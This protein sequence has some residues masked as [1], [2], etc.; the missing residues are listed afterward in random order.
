MRVQSKSVF[1][2]FCSILAVALAQSL[3][4]H[5]T[6]ILLPSSS[7]WN[8]DIAYVFLQQPSRGDF[9]LASINISSTLS[10][11]NLSLETLSTTLPFSTTG[12]D[13]FIPS[14]ST[15]GE[16]LVYAGTC[17]TSDGASLWTFTPTNTSSV[18]NGTWIKET[19]TAGN[20]SS[21]DLLGADFLSRGFSFS[22]LV[23]ANASQ[24][25]TYIFGGMCPKSGAT[26]STW[27]SDASYSNRMLRLT[28]GSSDYTIEVATS[29]G[30][31]I[32]EAGF[33]ITGLIPTY[34]N[35][36]GVVTQQQDFVLIGGH[37]QT[38]FI[39]M[40]QLAIWNLPEANW[41][42]IPVQSSSASPNTELAVKSTVTSVDSRSG[43]T[44]VLTEDGS[45]II[46]LGGWVGDITQAADPQLVVLEVGAGYGGSGASKDWKWSIPT[47]QP[48]GSGIYGHGA[49]MLPGNV[50]MVLGGYNITSSTKLKRDP[51]SGAQVMFLNAT[52]MT[53]ISNYTN[54]SYVAALEMDAAKSSSSSKSHSKK[55]GLGVGLGLGLAAV[56]VAI[57]VYCW[58][59]KRARD[60][61][62]EERE[63]HIRALSAGT[64]NY[65]P[66]LGQRSGFPW[67]TGW[68]PNGGQDSAV[69]GYENL[70]SGIHGLGDHGIPP[71]PK[72]TVRKPLHSQSARGLYQPTSTFDYTATDGRSNS[73]G[74]AGPIHPI[75]EADEDD[76]V[77]V[78]S[79]NGVGVAFGDPSSP[80]NR[81]QHPDI[82]R[83][84]PA[85]NSATLRQEDFNNVAPDPETIARSR[86]REIEEWVSD[87]AAAD[88]LLH[89]QARSH[90]SAG[91]VSPTRRA[92]LAAATVSS[93]SSEGDI[94]RNASNSSGRSV[95]ISAMTVS[96]SGSSSQSRPRSNSL[97]RLVT[98][99]IN[100]FTSNLLSPTVGSAGPSPTSDTR[101]PPNSS[102]SGSSSF[103]TA[104]TTL[105]IMHPPDEDIPPRRGEEIQTY[106]GENSP[107]RSVHDYV[108]GSPSK[109][110]PPAV[111]KG[112]NSWLEGLKRA[113]TGDSTRN[114]NH[115]DFSFGTRTPSPMLIKQ[116]RGIAPRR[117][118]S[119]GAAG[120][121]LWR[122]RQGRGDWEDSA[123]PDELPRGA[124]RSSAIVGN[125]ASHISSSISGD[126]EDEWDIERA[127]QN[128]VV[129]VM[130]TVPKER[131]RVVNHDIRDEGSETSTIRSKK[132]ISRSIRSTKEATAD[133]SAQTPLLEDAGTDADADTDA[134]PDPLDKGKGKE[135][136][137]SS[138]KSKSSSSKPK[139]K[140]AE[141]VEKLEERLTPEHY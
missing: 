69:M 129:Q 33:T 51:T 125:R 2:T 84:P 7:S 38:A 120:A 132:S 73:L 46:V 4:Y 31:P 106:S 54:P 19:I 105:P 96:R 107:T 61:G 85:A 92:Q 34:S 130:F 93:V 88:A 78:V 136:D 60:E 135:S 133:S 62:V 35:G 32:A 26:V 66:P 24:T 25:V 49:V 17:S 70:N 139:G 16:I 20:V 90:S 103:T 124:R 9:Y 123:D 45:K 102:G 127:V 104:R 36:S 27:Q 113:F 5:P 112:R 82:F 119:D 141:M 64:A 114:A 131:L 12:F 48:P 43:H 47:E 83:D 117:T 121:A 63:K 100:P 76:H 13:T 40:S 68:G 30:P 87:W 80:A 21:T 108:P 1:W 28:P 65:S 53:W 6:N 67:P 57:V 95:A 134:D 94:N 11:G 59:R 137:T 29:R 116:H 50:M 89:S 10:P 86:E 3:P 91:H 115:D 126:D 79:D 71:P 23:D 122:R 55:V 8:K 111:N 98:S 52:S 22:P 99:A 138:V 109:T 58:L 101:K 15:N 118:A 74:T 97:R 140:V 110:K 75:Y 56:V 18:G 44:A 37:T 77:P 128:R 14:I 42:F 41:G 81:N 72:H 39:N